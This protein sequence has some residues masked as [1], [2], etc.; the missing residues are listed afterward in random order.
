MIRPHRPQDLSEA[1]V[2]TCEARLLEEVVSQTVSSAGQSEAA[3]LRRGPTRDEVI[4]YT[5]LRLSF[6]ANIL[7]HGLS[8]I[9][10]GRAA[11]LAYLTH[12]FEHSHLVPASLLPPFAAVLPWVETTLGLLL[13]LGLVTRFA[14]IVGALVLLGL[15]IGTNLAQ[16][17]LVA[18]L[19]LI[20][21]FIYYY[22]LVHLDQNQVSADR[23]LGIGQQ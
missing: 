10:N 16:D 1:D 7:L 2:Q 12:Y 17:W 20:Y 19:Q 8:R 11:F 13:M 5:I 18:G 3:S 14:L 22:L 21:C 15:V 4:A 6:G 23:S 9:L